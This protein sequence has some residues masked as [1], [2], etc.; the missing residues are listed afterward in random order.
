MRVLQ[1]LAAKEGFMPVVF[2]EL[3][4]NVLKTG[5][6]YMIPKLRLKRR[7]E[8]GLPPLPE[9]SLED[10]SKL[11][12]LTNLSKILEKRARSNHQ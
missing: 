7:A 2:R 8:K 10:I 3:V 4:S 6:A 9:A 12:N 5:H 1:N 11:F